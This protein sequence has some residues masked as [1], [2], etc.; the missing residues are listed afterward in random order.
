MLPGAVQRLAFRIPPRRVC[1]SV[2]S[3]RDRNANSRKQRNKI[4]RRVI[5]VV[6]CLLPVVVGAIWFS[7]AN[8]IID[9]I[10]GY[11]TQ[12]TILSR[13]ESSRESLNYNLKG[14]AAGYIAGEGNAMLAALE[15]LNPGYK[16]S[17]SK[18]TT[19]HAPGSAELQASIEAYTAEASKAVDLA[20]SAQYTPE[21]VA[22]IING[23]VFLEVDEQVALSVASARLGL[24]GATDR[25]NDNWK[26]VITAEL[27]ITLFITVLAIVLSLISER[28]IKRA[29]DTEAAR[30]EDRTNM[31]TEPFTHVV[32]T[33]NDGVLLL[34]DEQ[35]VL[36]ANPAAQ[37]LLGMGVTVGSNYNIPEDGRVEIRKADGSTSS[38]SVTTSRAV[39]GGQPVTILTIQA[40]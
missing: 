37:A 5:L 23:A 15:E 4:R 30:H 6:L 29:E 9:E 7:Y 35:L 22:S 20:L 27:V 3:K 21:G 18:V 13:T 33:M 10:N 8:K 39:T 1:E 28:A 14:A 36:H 12:S 19:P 25:G 16:N 26:F 32:A 31:A 34:S 17:M 40:D 11:N 2:A 38:A 24:T